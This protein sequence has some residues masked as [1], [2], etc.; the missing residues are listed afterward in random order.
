MPKVP[1]KNGFMDR[2]NTGVFGLD[3]I[4]NYSTHAIE[5]MADLVVRLPGAGIRADFEDFMC[6]ALKE[7]VKFLLPESGYLFADHDYSPK[8]FELQRLPYPICALEF[9]AGAELYAEGS[10]LQHASKRIALCFDPHLLPEKLSRLF[11][12]LTEARLSELPARCLAVTAIY[13]VE[14]SWAAAV[15]FVVVDLDD[16]MP[17]LLSDADKAREAG[18]TASD[19]AFRAGGRIKGTPA[20]HGLPSTFYTI[21]ERARLV[22]HSRDQAYEALYIDT[23]D[24]VRV[25]Y[26]FLAAINCANV[27]TQDVA[28]PEKLNQK[29]ARSGK[30]PF[31]PYKLLDLTPASDTQPGA[32]GE[33]GTSPRAHLRRGHLRRLGEKF[34]NKVLWINATM[35]N[36][37]AGAPL[38][39][40]YKVKS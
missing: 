3:Q 23:L 10:G 17:I 33:G 12:S 35:V 32:S 24:E 14:G 7:S 9:R 40:V 37:V 16:D 4:P 15:G 2:L 18:I 1:Q 25:T 39:T 19:I 26:E 6:T 34:G 36:T 22:G 28:A 31:Y 29:R 5:F 21:P 11:C 38:S 27:G 30:P 13:F 8:M 20:K